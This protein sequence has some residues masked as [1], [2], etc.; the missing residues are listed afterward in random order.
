[1]AVTLEKKSF[2]I[3]IYNNRSIIYS[4]M[5][6]M[7]KSKREVV[8]VSLPITQTDIGAFSQAIFAILGSYRI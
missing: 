3:L 1:M 2:A 8:R 6:K 5:A 7:A 4:L